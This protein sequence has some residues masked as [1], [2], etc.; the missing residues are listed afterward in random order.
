[1]QFGDS[2]TGR[3]LQCAHSEQ[4]AAAT[5]SQPDFGVNP[6][7]RDTVWSG[8]RNQQSPLPPPLRMWL[9]DLFSV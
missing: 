9:P 4:E 6:P 5:G 8:L 7:Y 3:R 2:A 1:M